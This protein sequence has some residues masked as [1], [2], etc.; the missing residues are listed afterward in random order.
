MHAAHFDVDELSVWQHG[1]LFLLE[2]TQISKKLSKNTILNASDLRCE[3]KFNNT[4]NHL[5]RASCGFILML[6]TS[7]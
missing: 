7:C 1:E 4:A 2:E 3:V 5:A 6:T